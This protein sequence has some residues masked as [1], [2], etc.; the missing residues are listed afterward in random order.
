MAL[1]YKRGLMSGDLVVPAGSIIKLISVPSAAVAKLVNGQVDAVL[2]PEEK[3]ETPYS[4]A[5]DSTTV[6]I[7]A[8]GNE[9]PTILSNN[10]VP[11]F[12][13]SISGQ[14]NSATDLSKPGDEPV[15]PFGNQT[16]EA[17]KVEEK[18]NNEFSA[19]IDPNELLNQTQVAVNNQTGLNQSV[20]E[21]EAPDAG[22]VLQF[23]AG[24]ESQEESEA[25]KALKEA[26]EASIL[27]TQILDQ[28]I[29]TL[30]NPDQHKMAA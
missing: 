3:Q 22:K 16:S 7:P 29:N 13:Q 25:L 12:E 18:I 14:D 21:A 10:T 30:E 26:R 9:A 1:S 15:I 19:P 5:L 20:I 24:Y 23:P 2:Q 17:P 28:K 4:A 6:T 8:S 27:T 11:S